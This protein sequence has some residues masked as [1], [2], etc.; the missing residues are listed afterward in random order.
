MGLVAAGFL[1]DFGTFLGGR[2]RMQ[3]GGL[4]LRNGHIP[5][6]QSL[7]LCLMDVG[8]LFG[9]TRGGCGGERGGLVLVPGG[10]FVSFRV[11]GRR[12]AEGETVP[13]SVVG[14]M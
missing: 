3:A 10:P 5:S 11:P 9:R 12:T 14:G 13:T 2:H 4:V 7:S 1:S 6:G 8:G